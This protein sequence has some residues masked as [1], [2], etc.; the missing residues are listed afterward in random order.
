MQFSI[1]EISVL[2]RFGHNSI[3]F[4]GCNFIFLSQYAYFRE[5]NQTS[6][7]SVAFS[8][9]RCW[10]ISH[11]NDNISQY[12]VNAKWLK[13]FWTKSMSM[14]FSHLLSIYKTN[15]IK[16][17][18]QII[19]YDWNRIYISNNKWTKCKLLI[20]NKFKLKL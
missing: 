16:Y 6:S 12:C 18:T 20:K 3:Y 5:Y 9:M 2:C 1:I 10:K 8:I 11:F 14:H 7:W 19:Q 4:H 13:Q 15:T 17:T